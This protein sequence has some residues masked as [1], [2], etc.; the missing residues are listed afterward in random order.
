MTRTASAVIHLAV[1]CSHPVVTHSK[2]QIN[3]SN[4]DFEVHG[5]SSRSH[6]AVILQLSAFSEFTY[7]GSPQSFSPRLGFL[8]F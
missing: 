2:C 3:G 6:P 7:T 5:Q 4:F 8:K 1:I